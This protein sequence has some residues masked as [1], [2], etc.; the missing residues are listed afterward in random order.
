MCQWIGSA[1]VQVIACRLFGVRPLPEPM[2]A[3]CQLDCWK[4]ISARS[5]S[6]LR[7]MH[8]RHAPKCG[9]L[10]YPDHIQS[11]IRSVLAQL[12]AFV[13]PKNTSVNIVRLISVGPIL[14]LW[15]LQNFVKL[16]FPSILRRIAE[17]NGLKRG[18]LTYPDNFHSVK[19]TN[20]FFFE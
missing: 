5:P 11:W 6:I 16:E 18:M 7:R 4:Q 19:V 14:A 15:W 10:M 9:M 8:G 17:R 2:L 12:W 20:S 3:Y 13:G 1:L